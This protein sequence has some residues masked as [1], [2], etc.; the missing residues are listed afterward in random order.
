M[1]FVPFAYQVTVPL[2]PGLITCGRTLDEARE[3]ASDAIR[4]HIEGLRKD[5][6]PI[7]DERSTREEK[8][9]SPFRGTTVLIYQLRFKSI[10]RQAELT[11]EE[12]LSL[13]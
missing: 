6:E 2:L 13:C 5:G 4:C 3:M 1:A 8:C 10:L 9:E 7:P 11:T 12:F